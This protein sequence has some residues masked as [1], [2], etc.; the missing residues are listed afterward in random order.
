MGLVKKYASTYMCRDKG[1]TMIPSSYH[2]I[3]VTRV[4]LGI[5][6]AGLFPGAVY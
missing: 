6:E 1:L 3:L 4:L 2:Q 5:V